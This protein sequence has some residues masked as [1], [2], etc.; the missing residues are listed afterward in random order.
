MFEVSAVSHEGLRE[1][2]F[3]L[4]GIVAE[5]R[6][7]GPAPAPRVVLR[8]SAVDEAG[9]TVTPERTGGSPDALRYRVRGEK[10][11]RWVRQTDFAND[12]AVGYLADRL[13][14]LGVEEALFA[15]GAV[16][17]SEVVI[18]DDATG[19]VFDWEPTLVSGPGVLAGPRGG[20]P[21]LAD[22]GRATRDERRERYEA[23]RQAR[24]DARA[25]LAEERRAGVWTD[26]DDDGTDDGPHGDGPHGDGADDDGPH[27]DRPD[28]DGPD[29]DRPHG[30]RPDDER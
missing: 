29:D 21:R 3:A 17:G 5:A 30:D 8:P 19:V 16:A 15:A 14:R 10:P 22:G 2:S 12:E 6:A 18:G 4:A 24:R 11:E 23:R 1:L 28:G 27:G 20:D 13:A 7:A 9:F 25:E 26:P